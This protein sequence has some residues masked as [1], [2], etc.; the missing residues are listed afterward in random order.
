MFPLIGEA[1]S[2][3]SLCDASC[4]YAH[5]A[6]VRKLAASYAYC[7]LQILN[8]RIFSISPQ[9]IVAGPQPRPSPKRLSMPPP[10]PAYTR[11]V[12]PPPAPTPLI[13]PTRTS[14]H[15]PYPSTSRLLRPSP[16]GLPISSAATA[17]VIIAIDLMP[18]KLRNFPSFRI[19]FP[20]ES[21]R[22]GSFLLE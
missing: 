10:P 16:P 1:A 19:W 7:A 11:P 15:P 20:F 18:E 3:Q 12:C 14:S 2:A 9:L 8:R 6:F 4:I 22:F 5:P 13:L 17:N 21:L